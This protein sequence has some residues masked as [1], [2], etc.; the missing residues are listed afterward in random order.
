MIHNYRDCTACQ[1][2]KKRRRAGA[3]GL[4]VIGLVFAALVSGCFPYSRE[5]TRRWAREERAAAEQ[6]GQAAAPWAV[7]T[8]THEWR[9]SSRGD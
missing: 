9:G 8:S 7:L 5:T 1:K 2:S 4:I 3:A 6:S